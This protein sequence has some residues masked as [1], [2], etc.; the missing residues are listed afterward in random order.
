M[1]RLWAVTIV[2][3]LSPFRLCELLISGARQVRRLRTVT[4]VVADL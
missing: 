3:L 2:P 1:V 4:G